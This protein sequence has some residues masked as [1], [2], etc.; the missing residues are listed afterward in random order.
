MDSTG[1]LEVYLLGDFRL[2]WDDQPVASFAQARLQILLA[3]LLLHR[4]TPIARRQLAFA[5]WPDTDDEQALSNLRTLLHRLREV[6]PEGQRFLEMNRH[7]ITWRSDAALQLDV[8]RFEDALAQAVHAPQPAAAITALQAAV[9][10][11]SGDL[12]PDCYDEWIIPQRERLRQDFGQALEQLISLQEGQR[13]TEGAIRNTRRLLRFDP[14]HEA[15]H[16]QLMRL[17]LADGDRARALRAYHRCATTLRRELGVDPGPATQVLYQRLLH[18]DDESTSAASVPT[19]STGRVAPPRLVGR[20]AEW[21]TMLDIWHTATA[22]AEMILVS[23]EAGAGATRLAEELATWVWRQGGDVAVARCHLTSHCLPYA[24]V[25]DWLRSPALQTRLAALDDRRLAE[26]ARL[27]PEIVGGRRHPQSNQ[28]LANPGPLIEEWQRQRFLEALTAPLVAKGR[29]LLLWVDD[30]HHGDRESLEWLQYLLDKAGEAPLLVLGTAHAEEVQAGHPLVAL[31]LSLQQRGRWHEIKLGPLSADETFELAA[32]LAGRSLTPCEA[33]HLYYDSEG[34]PLF[35]VETI[36]GGLLIPA[37]P[38]PDA[39]PDPHGPQCLLCPRR[40]TPSVRVQAIVEQRLAHLSPASRS[41]AQTA[42]VIGRQFTLDLLQR[43]CGLDETALAQAVDELWRRGIVREQGVEGYDFSH[44]KLR[45]AAYAELSLSRRRFLQRRVAEAL[46]ETQAGLPGSAALLAHHFDEAGDAER[47]AALWLQAGDEARAMAAAAKA[48]ACYR[49]AVAILLSHGDHTGAGLAMM[50]LGAAHHSAFDFE[51][52]QAAYTEGFGLLARQPTWQAAPGNTSSSPLATLRLARLVPRTI[53][54][55]VDDGRDAW[56]IDQLFA[57][58]VAEGP[59]M[60]ILPDVARDWQI[61]DGGRT[62]TFHLRHDVVWSDGVPVTA[63]DF[64]CAWRRVL[65]PAVAPHYAGLLFD[66]A[67]AHAFQSGETTQWDQ[68][69][70]HALDRTTL[71]VTL[72]EPAN[73]F[74]FVLAHRVAFP[75]P[76]HVVERCGPTWTE[77]ANLVSNG[78]FL[79]A[80]WQPG[81][82][83]TLARNP[84]Y[85]GRYA[86]NVGEVQVRLVADW[87]EQVALYEAGQLDAIPIHRLH[88]SE[89][90]RLHRRHPSEFH[91]VPDLGVDYIAFD[92][93]RPPFDDVRVRRA[94]TLAI[95]RDCVANGLMLGYELPASGGLTPPTLPGHAAGIALPF[96]PAQAQHLLAEAGYPQGEGLPAIEL[97]GGQ[98]SGVWATVGEYL[99][100]QWQHVLGARIDRRTVPASELIERSGAGGPH[101]F[102]IGW[103]A[104]YPDADNFLRVTPIG[105]QTG[106]RH[107]GYDAIV[108]QARGTHDVAERQRLYRQAETILAAEAPILPLTYNNWYMLLKL[109]VT[110]FPMSA[111]RRWFLKDVVVALD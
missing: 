18:A 64:E 73:S 45:A 108:A 12:L 72:V 55:G 77:P 97:W 47:A 53:D 22:S 30:L 46:Q 78:P 8:A 71:Q 49:R 42:A 59:D 37:E 31:R 67:G 58:L 98:G 52:A 36:R 21:T 3:F 38:Q 34:N 79:L 66:I 82:A 9:D 92:T 75:V 68:V 1:I 109:C 50:R 26:I 48:D 104:D 56:L 32:S 43:A 103:R 88:R 54:P 17:H 96:A 2:T 29:P 83:L 44:E 101:A 89:T 6:L 86:G 74:L 62:Y 70:I 5:L 87:S 19:A 7:S 65:D 27:A 93:R 15:G 23:G 61:G 102:C 84:D 94:F 110:S 81:Q 33:R 40:I 80:D 107:A 11:Y 41:L 35:L 105:R 13:Q 91:T 60:A 16:R 95:D 24:I 111:M 69:G 99:A 63:G 90:I 100:Q 51:A 10:A 57:G 20:Q 76:R 28:D 25:A 4:H 14:L 85:H 39:H 106:W